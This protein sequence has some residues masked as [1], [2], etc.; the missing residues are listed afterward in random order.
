MEVSYEDVEKL[1]KIIDSAPVG[2]LYLE[3]GDFKLVVKKTGAGSTLADQADIAQASAHVAFRAVPP[4]AVG[5]ETTREGLSVP[6]RGEPARTDQGGHPA[7]VGSKGVEV[8]S[9]TG[10]TF[11]RAPLPGAPPFVSVGD[12][13]SELDT[14]CIVE[15]MKLMNSI[16]AGCNGRVVEICV[17]DGSTVERDQTLMVIESVSEDGCPQVED[18]KEPGSTDGTS[19]RPG[20]SQDITAQD[21]FREQKGT[22]AVP[23]GLA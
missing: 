3:M 2:E 6:A 7:L 20:A 14:V 8:R 13:V 19:M 1:L 15:V 5:A 10:G 17:E 4:T 18:G 16:P 9:P 22:S 11:Y 12:R 23:P 21:R